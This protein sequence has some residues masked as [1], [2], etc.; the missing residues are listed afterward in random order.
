MQSSL[1]STLYIFGFITLFITVQSVTIHPVS[2][3]A[4]MWTRKDSVSSVDGLFSSS[5]SQDY[6]SSKRIIQS[7]FSNDDFSTDSPIYSSN[8]GFVHAAIEAYSNHHHLIIRP[9]DVWISI[10]SQIGFFIKNHAEEMRNVF[11][12]HEGKIKLV[13]DGI[14]SILNTDFGRMAVEMTEMV[15]A[16]IKD[17]TLK[18]WYMPNFTTTTKTDQVVAAIQLMGSMQKYFRYEFKIICGLPSVTLLGERSDW[19]NLLERVEMLKDWGLEP[20]FFYCRVKPVI[21]HFVMSFDDPHSD[22]VVDFWNNIV[23]VGY[24]CGGPPSI[25]G[26]ITA[27]TFWGNDGNL[28]HHYYY[29]EEGEDSLPAWYLD[30]SCHEYIIYSDINLDVIPDGFASVPVTV[31]DN[32]AIHN[33]NI[34]AG[35]V[36]ICVTSSG[37]KLNQ[38]GTWIEDSFK[39]A[40]QQAVLAKD[41]PLT[42][43][44]T[45]QPIVGWWMY[46]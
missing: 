10:L 4:N 45:L 39:G 8:N 35:S 2:H 43:L 38:S 17:P 27:F 46:E 7:S 36:G 15:A 11:V 24:G 14:G 19:Q 44:D 26:W 37:E 12:S 3:N 41:R 6:K 29:R 21:E 31:D 1:F 28:L 22:A 40:Y 16:N 13:V 18:D 32:G 20:S 30:A 34:V 9:D 23:H 33:T 5:C 25:N 42:G